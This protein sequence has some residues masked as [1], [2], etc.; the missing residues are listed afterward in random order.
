MKGT[1]HIV[2]EGGM[3][4]FSFPRL[5]AE[6]GISAP[7][8]YEHYKNKKDL[9]TTCFMTIDTEVSSM[10]AA[11]LNSLPSKISDAASLENLCWLLWISYWNYLTVAADRTLFYW[12]FYNSHYYTPELHKK[13]DGN[14]DVFLGFISTVDKCFSV[15]RKYNPRMLVTNMIDGTVSMAVKVLKGFYPNDDVTAHTVYSMVFQPIFSMLDMKNE[16]RTTSSADALAE[17]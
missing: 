8:V 7:T 5:T 4:N 10:I 6:T 3:I 13:R 1:Q 16:E 2:A 15:S 12:S 9:L 14:F 11:M 17:Q